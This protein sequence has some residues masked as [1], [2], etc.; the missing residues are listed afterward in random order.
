M[1]IPANIHTWKQLDNFL[2]QNRTGMGYHVRQIS[3]GFVLANGFGVTIARTF[4]A[5][6]AH[7]R[8]S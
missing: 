7:L 8:D 4:S 5:A 1:N 3:P 2:Y 6:I